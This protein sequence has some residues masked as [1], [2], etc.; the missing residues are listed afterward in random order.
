MK[1][2]RPCYHGDMARIGIYPG[3]FDPVHAGHIAF[4][5]AA[6]LECQLDEVVFLP[7]KTPRGKQN[8]TATAHRVALLEK[9]IENTAGLRVAALASER[10]TVKQT[11]PELRALFGD[12]EL[13]LLLGSDVALS[14]PYW[15]DVDV[16]LQEMQIAVG[17]RAGDSRQEIIE[18]LRFTKSPA[19]Y[20]VIETEHPHFTSSQVRS[21]K[22]AL[23]SPGVA[24]YARAHS[25]YFNL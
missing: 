9:A 25:L 11:L 18:I 24:E 14:L 15:P 12:A 2:G 16:L 23:F 1:K 8:V 22:T 10:F 13:T 17:M 20:T 4:A 21:G 7:E 6:L 5:T 19:T 3:T